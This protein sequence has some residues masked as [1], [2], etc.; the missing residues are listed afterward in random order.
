MTG[1]D[2]VFAFSSD[3]NAQRKAKAVVLARWLFAQG[4]TPDDGN[5]MDVEERKD[6]ERR[7]GR[8]RGDSAKPLTTS[9]RDLLW[10]IALGALAAKYQWHAEHPQIIQSPEVLPL[11]A[12]ACCSQPGQLYPCG[13]RCPDHAPATAGRDTSP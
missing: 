4:I 13:L 12:C 6:A 8:A 9:H 3:A 5:L 2:D 11:L 7:A 10:N 1:E